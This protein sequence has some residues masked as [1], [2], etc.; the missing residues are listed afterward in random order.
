MDLI[1]D[2]KDH[3]KKI[4]LFKS[5]LVKLLYGTDLEFFSYFIFSQLSPLISI[6]N[7]L[8]KK[9]YELILDENYIKINFGYKDMLLGGEIV[10][11]H[12]FTL[13][14]KRKENDNLF[15][16]KSFFYKKFK[17]LQLKFIPKNSSLKIGGNEL[18]Q[19]YNI[20]NEYN[21]NLLA[22][23]FNNEKCNFISYKL[24][25]QIYK[26]T[27]P[28]ICELFPEANIRNIEKFIF[29][30]VDFIYSDIKEI[31]KINIKNVKYL[32][33]GTGGNYYN[34]IASYLAKKNNIEVTRFA[35]SLDRVFF[36]DDYWD[37]ELMGIDNY[38]N[39]SNFSNININSANSEFIKLKSNKS[40]YYEQIFNDRSKFNNT[41][42]LK[43]RFLFIGQAYL[44]EARQM[45]SYKLLDKNQLILEKKI[46]EISKNIGLDI[47]YRPHP[48]GHADKKILKKYLNLE[49]AEGNLKDN[50]KDYEYLIFTS[51]GMAAIEAIICGK[52]VFYIDLGIR[53]HSDA[54]IHL[55]KVI[56][57]IDV[58]N[59]SKMNKL[60]D[61]LQK[62][63]DNFKINNNDLLN[64][65][66][67][68][69]CNI[70]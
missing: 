10:N 3:L 45:Y 9:D 22:F 20:E 67:L 33:S 19:S 13:L 56:K 55:E 38:V 29:K 57:V 51:I 17:K 28:F 39:F 41:N 30:L 54:F 8:S 35:H 23:L 66:N 44:G 58:G 37:Y 27:V 46:I 68:F 42:N 14:K 61:I 32:Y 4:N 31:D 25:N 70:K 50:F 5:Q 24:H 16:V 49:F 65:Y 64:F 40:I 52:K 47:V 53:N 2:Q 21:I 1:I 43:N 11:P 7:D 63:I 36:L 60:G 6:A 18:M 26:L 69:F 62:N 48:K 12:F 15:K 34:I 59:L